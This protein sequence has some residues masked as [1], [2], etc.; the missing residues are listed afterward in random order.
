MTPKYD[1]ISDSA[2][3][4]ILGNEIDISLS[5]RIASLSAALPPDGI[6]DRVPSYTTLLIQF[7]PHV[8]NV[9]HLIK[10]V[11][12]L[13][14]GCDEP[15]ST[16]S[17]DREIVIPVAYGGRHGP[18]LAVV[19]RHAGLSV[20]EVVLKHSAAVYSVG[21]IG[22]SPGFGYLS[23]L[24]PELATPRLPIP[25]LRVP[26]GSLA[27]GA[28][29]SAVYPV[30]TAGGWNIIGRT[31]LSLFDSDRPDPFLLRVGDTVRFRSV[32]NIP[33]SPLIRTYRKRSDSQGIAV[34]TPGLLTTIQDLGRFGYGAFGI[35]P[36]G[37]ADQRASRLGN[38]LV[39]ND[40]SA[41][42]LE[43]TLVGPHLR[44]DTGVICAVTG[45]GPDPRLNGDPIPR[46]QAFRAY[47]GDHLAF[48]PIDKSAGARCYLAIAGGFDVPVVMGS[49]STDLVAGI[50][51]IEG[52]AL[53]QGDVLSTGK[54]THR[55]IFATAPE[56]TRTRT[57]LRIMPGPQ[58]SCFSDTTWHRLTQ[59]EFRVTND[60]NR[61][62]IRLEGP[63]LQPRQRIEM[64]S[65]GVVTG[66]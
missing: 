6:V 57:R 31:S 22:F 8:L 14:A 38:R 34:L 15:A 5:R 50:G 43:I 17:T 59:R 25:R 41:S 35:S 29:Q 46:N 37:A 52:R 24:P 48:D 13:W 62:G 66:S 27:I 56:P 55:P 47:L 26:E 19:A 23:G 1:L 3:L 42:V 28:A 20:N 10:L 32:R 61:V 2:V 30:E 33:V 51:G 9:G 39:G 64:I 16:S 65:E 4:F 44:F 12:E 58:R 60:A 40:Q 7:D 11:A 53:I 54:P 36:N 45:E 18:D 49:R 21:A 63:A